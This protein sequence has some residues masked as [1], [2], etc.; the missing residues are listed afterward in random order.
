MAVCF[1]AFAA[2]AVV[3]AGL[4]IFGIVTHDLARRRFEFA[5]RL[6]LGANPARLQAAIARRAAAIVAA[7]P[8]PGVLLATV[9]SRM[10]RSVLA[11]IDSTDP[12]AFAA[13]AAVLLFVV[14]IA[15]A[16]PARRVTRTDPALVLRSD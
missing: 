1:L 15:I 5:L 2:L 14:G 4:G 6:A 11:D 12:V 7:G 10:L 8:V 13:V 16:A 3:V 9:A